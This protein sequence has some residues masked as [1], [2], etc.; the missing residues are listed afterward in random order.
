LINTE[1]YIGNELWM[2]RAQLPHADR[3]LNPVGE[4]TTWHEGFLVHV[5]LGSLCGRP[6]NDACTRG[7]V[8]DYGLR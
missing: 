4:A 8:D 6:S 2:E 3:C 5:A 7:Q 1:G